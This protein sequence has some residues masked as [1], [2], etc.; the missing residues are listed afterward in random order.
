MPYPSK[1]VKNFK[2]IIAKCS[3]LGTKYGVKK[4]YI[5]IIIYKQ[6]KT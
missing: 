5:F 4:N 2:L 6:I 1:C 3:P